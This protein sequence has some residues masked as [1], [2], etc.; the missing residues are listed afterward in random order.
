[1]RIKKFLHAVLVLRKEILLVRHTVMIK[2]LVGQ[3]HHVTRWLGPR[4]LFWRSDFV[5]RKRE[6]S[7]LIVVIKTK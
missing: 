7:F 3:V 1:M 6:T 5:V 2:H 4:V